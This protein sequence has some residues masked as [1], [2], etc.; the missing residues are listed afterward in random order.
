MKTPL[1]FLIPTSKL[2]SLH[3]PHITPLSQ[4]F[5]L[6]TSP[7]SWDRRFPLHRPR[8][9]HILTNPRVLD[10]IVR[11]AGV[12]SDDSV[13]EVGPGT[14][15]LTV[16]LLGA[17]RHVTAVEIDERM[18]EALKER[19]E[20]LGLSHKLTVI[21][22]DAMKMQFP[23][24]STCVANIPYGISSPLIAKLLFGQYQFRTATLLLQKEFAYRLTALPGDSEYNRLAANIRLV[25][26]A[27]LIMDVS[28]RDFAP[29]PKVDS[30][31]VTIRPRSGSI[32]PVDL[33]EWLGFT[34]VCFSKK[35]KTLGAIF[36][37]KRMVLELFKRSRPEKKNCI[38]GEFENIVDLESDGEGESEG[39]EIKQVDP[40]ELGLFR[41]TIGKVLEKV[42][43]N[44]KR[45]SKITNEDLL[46]LLRAF[47]QEGVF[48]Q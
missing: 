1:R 43:S 47:N 40:H 46:C 13:L 28:K 32:I 45:P 10:A 14:G 38:N 11:K 37:Q 41:E 26:E 8:G 24:F 2:L 3:K 15:N 27:E 9:Q 34:R 17:A 22:G 39:K 23:Y 36:K 31:L 12:G 16:R 20:N 19:V 42:G 5:L 4:S 35:N 21:R 6:H 18:V 44:E 33:K 7:D 25:A 48:F 29:V 30:S